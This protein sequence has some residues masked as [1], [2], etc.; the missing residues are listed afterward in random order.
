MPCDIVAVVSRNVTRHTLHNR[1]RGIVES[2]ARAREHPHVGVA[3]EQHVVGPVHVEQSERS[4]RVGHARRL[5]QIPQPTERSGE[6]LHGRVVGGLRPFAQREQ[7]T[8]RAVV[9]LEPFR[10]D[11]PV[12]PADVCEVEHQLLHSALVHAGKRDRVA[13]VH[14][15]HS[16]QYD[17]IQQDR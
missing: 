3:F 12:F 2:L 5:W 10:V 15:L 16:T 6:A 1:G 11:H 13:R 17:I 14:G 8:T 4:K 7:A 9:G